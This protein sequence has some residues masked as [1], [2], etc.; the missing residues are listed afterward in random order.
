MKTTSFR[1]RR[2]YALALFSNVQGK[3]IRICS[4]ESWFSSTIKREAQA[5]ANRYNREHGGS[6][7]TKFCAIETL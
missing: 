6:I 5:A 7:E 3:I 4:V 1:N 2:F